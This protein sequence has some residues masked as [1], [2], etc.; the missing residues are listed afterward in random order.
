MALRV[1]AHHTSFAVKDLERS[2]FFYEQVLGLE[3]KPRPDLGIPGVWYQA[4]AC[5]VHLIEM[6]PGLDVGA[7][8]PALN[9]LARHEAFGI[10]DYDEALAELRAHG[11]EVLETN[12]EQGQMWTRDPDGNIIEL[13]VARDG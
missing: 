6:L 7:A 8:P 13:I 1:R 10:R 3:P 11:L 9:P 4:G 5:E 12:R 2:R